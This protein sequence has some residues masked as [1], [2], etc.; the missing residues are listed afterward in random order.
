MEVL[1]RL[2]VLWLGVLGLVGGIE[3]GRIV[4]WGNFGYIVEVG[5]GGL[6][7][8][9]GGLAGWRDGGRQNVSNVRGTRTGGKGWRTM[10]MR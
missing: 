5:V 7:G 8:W 6:V 1:W 3:V 9:V 10:R 2:G 4:G